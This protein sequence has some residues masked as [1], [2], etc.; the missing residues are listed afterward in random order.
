[1]E[2]IVN[3][4]KCKSICLL[5]L[6]QPIRGFVMTTNECH[7]NTKERKKRPHLRKYKPERT[8]LWSQKWSKMTLV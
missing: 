6:I 2:L 1:M 4:D 5:S 3:P 8:K 7:V